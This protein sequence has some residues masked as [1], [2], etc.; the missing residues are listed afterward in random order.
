MGGGRGGAGEEGWAIGKD[1]FEA[2]IERLERQE[3]R[4]RDTMVLVEA[5]LRLKEEHTDAADRVDELLREADAVLNFAAGT[6][7]DDE[8]SADRGR[9]GSSSGAGGSGPGNDSSGGGG[10]GRRRKKHPGY[11]QEDDSDSDDGEH[12]ARIMRSRGPVTL[13]EAF[14]LPLLRSCVAAAACP[15]SS[16]S[17]GGSV[18]AGKGKGVRDTAAAARRAKGWKG[19]GKQQAGSR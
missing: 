3:S 17:L 15:S 13:T 8:V 7:E 11:V 14:S 16:S 18:D 12:Q 6:T 9:S 5:S 10:S 4:A 19:K 1:L 2:M